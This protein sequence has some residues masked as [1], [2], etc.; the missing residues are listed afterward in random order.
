M[1]L[2]QFKTCTTCKAEKH[3]AEYHHDNRTPDKKCNRCKSCKNSS[4][5]VL[6]KP[7]QQ[8]VVR[9]KSPQLVVSEKMPI[10]Q[11]NLL[12]ELSQILGHHYSLSVGKNG[13]SRLQVHT[14]HKTET[15]HA[16]SP[17]KLVACVGIHFKQASSVTSKK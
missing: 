2:H 11:K 3:I 15:Y 12:S 17:E 1:K 16:L 10:T 9:P 8:P 5:T 4:R 13:K 14:P 7:L 6:K